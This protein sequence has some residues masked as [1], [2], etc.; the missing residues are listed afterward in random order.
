MFVSVELLKIC[1]L[2]FVKFC[3]KNSYYI[4]N[5]YNNSTDNIYFINL[6]CFIC[7]QDI[8]LLETQLEE[9]ATKALE[10]VSNY[11]LQLHSFLQNEERKVIELFQQMAQQPQ[12]QLRQVY[13]KFNESQEKL[14]VSIDIHMCVDVQ[15]PKNCIQ[16]TLLRFDFRQCDPIC[17]VLQII[18]LATYIWVSSL[19]SATS[20]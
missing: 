1:F 10:N 8:K 3:N 2:I 5:V 15:T 14:N 9:Y 18:H 7:L 19:K 4:V 11:F 6:F 12:F 13:A 16:L 20:S 17:S